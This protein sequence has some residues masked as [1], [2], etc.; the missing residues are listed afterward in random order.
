[1]AAAVRMAWAAVTSVWAVLM[2]PVR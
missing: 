1:V 2:A